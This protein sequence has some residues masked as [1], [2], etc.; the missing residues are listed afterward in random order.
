[1]QAYLHRKERDRLQRMAAANTP[2][3]RIASLL[4][5]RPVKREEPDDRPRKPLG[6]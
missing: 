1:V 4:P 5:A 2:A 3:E 6:L